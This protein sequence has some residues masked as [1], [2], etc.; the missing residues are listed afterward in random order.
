MATVPTA[1]TLGPTASAWREDAGAASA[2][3][4]RRRTTRRRTRLPQPPREVLAHTQR[5]GHDRERRI[6]G[7]ARRKE[8]R[9]DDVKVVDFVGAAVR[10]QRRGGRVEAEAHGAVLVRHA[11]E[12]DALA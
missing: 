2:S 9:V 11:R 8:R 12:G 3:A 1:L 10:I 5:V 6:D 7:G 4:S